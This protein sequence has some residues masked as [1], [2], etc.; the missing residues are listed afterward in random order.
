MNEQYDNID[1]EKTGQFIKRLR[2]SHNM[3][4]E[5]LGSKLFVTRKAVSKW[6]TGNS[7]PSI[8]VLKR[9]S[10]TF[11]VSLDDLIYG[12]FKQPIEPESNS[13]VLANIITERVYKSKKMIS[14]LLLVVFIVVAYFYYQSSTKVYT[15]NYEDKNF[16][17]TNGAIVLSPIKNYASLGNV[18][19]N[20]EENEDDI[21]V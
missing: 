16:S 4:Q 11:G 20:L 13:V 6:E 8:D 21:D 14:N 2:T 12:D 19:S 1:P 18:F 15:I 7:C 17:I 5:E 9:L 10:T 3:T